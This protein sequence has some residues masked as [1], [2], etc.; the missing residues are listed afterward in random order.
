MTRTMLCAT[1][2]LAAVLM[3]MASTGRAELITDGSFEVGPTGYASAAPSISS[4]G[5]GAWQTTYFAG[6]T[7][8]YS[9]SS[10][11][12]NNGIIPDGNQVAFVEGIYYPSSISQAVSG[13]TPGTQ[14]LVSFSDNATTA[15]WAEPTL[16]VYIDGTQEFTQVVAPVEA[17]GSF[18]QPY[19]LESFTF[20]ATS[21]TQTL[22]FQ[23]AASGS[24][25]VALI[26]NVLMTPVS[27][28]PE[29]GTLALLASGIM[30]L[31]VYAWRKRR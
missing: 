13:L 1:C 22:K 20:T 14:Y 10:P 12:G 26:D 21:D 31:S 29:P 8:A 2:V 7:G 9:G 16:G 18:T 4:I 3:A 25:N 19:H 28:V 15:P 5:D 6:V 27:S 23:V 24:D 11:F 17:S 30:G